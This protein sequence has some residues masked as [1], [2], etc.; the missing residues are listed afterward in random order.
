MTNTIV[1]LLYKNNH[2]NKDEIEAYKF[3][4]F[5]IQVYYY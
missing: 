4:C 1:D 2:I 5:Q 3:C